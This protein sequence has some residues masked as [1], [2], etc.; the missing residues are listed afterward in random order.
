MTASM[1][2]E[3]GL[4]LFQANAVVPYADGLHYHP[5]LS[6]VWNPIVLVPSATGASCGYCG[7]G[8]TRQPLMN[9]AFCDQHGSR[10][11][12]ATLVHQVNPKHWN[13]VR[14][15]LGNNSLFRGV[16][17]HDG[18][19]YETDIDWMEARKLR[20][21]IGEMMKYGSM[22]ENEATRLMNSFYAP[23][24]ITDLTC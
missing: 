24:K 11:S 19:F 8:L 1:L 15:Y 7:K 23:T 13:G 9:L 20:D 6:H 2:A 17:Y 4:V 14:Q 22:S 18:D 21:H 16:F 12:Y 3:D 5:K 10:A